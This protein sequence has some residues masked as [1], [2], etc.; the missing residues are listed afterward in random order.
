M[1][2]SPRQKP[3]NA[4]RIVY[5]L[6]AIWFGSVHAMAT[7]SPYYALVYERYVTAQSSSQPQSQVFDC[8]AHWYSLTR[9]IILKDNN[10][11]RSRS[12]SPPDL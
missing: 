12:V 7:V 3:W 8:T 10:V 9:P 5:E 6:M 1:E 11:R 4:E 2:T